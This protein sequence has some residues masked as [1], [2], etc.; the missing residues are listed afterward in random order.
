MFHLFSFVSLIFEFLLILKRYV[1]GLPEHEERCMGHSQSRS[2]RKTVRY[3]PND[4]I[5]ELFLQQFALPD[6]MLHSRAGN[7]QQIRS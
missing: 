1:D 4:K 3:P 6:G 2:Q 5:L 7:Q